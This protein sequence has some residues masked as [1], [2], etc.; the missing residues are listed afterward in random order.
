MKTVADFILLGSEITVDSDC[1]HEIE[2]S[3]LI[4]RKAVTDKPRCCIKRQEHL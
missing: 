4:G 1:S 2:R 3:L